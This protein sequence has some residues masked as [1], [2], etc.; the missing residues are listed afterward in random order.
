MLRPPIA[1]TAMAGLSGRRREVD[2]RSR[3][4]QQVSR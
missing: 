1:E 3:F 4:L 2:L